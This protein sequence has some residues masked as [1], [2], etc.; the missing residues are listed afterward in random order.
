M[1]IIDISSL[2]KEDV[3]LALFVNVYLKSEAS[4]K[5][6]SHFYM[7]DEIG[8]YNVPSLFE[9]KELI[10]KLYKGNF[11]GYH[12]IDR[13]GCVRFNMDIST[14]TLDTDF[15]DNHHQTGINGIKTA[16]EV[17]HKLKEEKE[18]RQTYYNNLYKNLGVTASPST[19]SSSSNLINTEHSV[20]T[21]FQ[22]NINSDKRFTKSQEEGVLYKATSYSYIDDDVLKDYGFKEEQ[23][24]RSKDG[25]ANIVIIRALNEGNDYSAKN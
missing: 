8:I 21:L 14:N 11:R 13:I 4:K 16:T 1:A 9:I 22:K 2:E 15:Y 17:I 25:P 10:Q 3:I 23:W 12:P 19:S 7:R 24:E 5:L 20:K 6:E 18:K